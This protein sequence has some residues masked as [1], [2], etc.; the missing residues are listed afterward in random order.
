MAPDSSNVERVYRGLK[1][2]IL[3][4]EYSLGCRIDAQL[5]ADDFGTSVTPVRDALQ[6]LVGEQ[7]ME[8][9]P[10]GGFQAPPLTVPTLLD[11]YEWNHLLALLVAKLAPRAEEPL[12][13]LLQMDGSAELER[14]T[15]SLFELL[16]ARSGNRAHGRTISQLNERLHAARLAETMTFK[17]A[18]GELHRLVRTLDSHRRKAISDRLSAYHQRRKQQLLQIIGTIHSFHKRQA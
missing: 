2:R 13:A 1:Q 8:A 3:S 4:G 18:G 11:L 10:R 6:R 17:D 7:W 5:V 16:A 9:L 15:A 12:A 14:Q